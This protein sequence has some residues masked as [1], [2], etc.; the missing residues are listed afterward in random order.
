MSEEWGSV[1]GM[2]EKPIQDC[3][4]NTQVTDKHMKK[5][6]ISLVIGEIKIKIKQYTC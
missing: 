2:V 3:L 6:P 1:T 4:L 5:C